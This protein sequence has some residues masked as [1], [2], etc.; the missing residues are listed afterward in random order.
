MDGSAAAFI[1]AIDQV[2]AEV[3]AAP[4]RYIKILKPVRVEAGR[5]FAEFRPHDGTRVEI[6]IDFANLL[7]G[8]QVFA[9]DIIGEV[10]RR[11]LARA[12]TFGFLADIEGLWAK[13]FALGASLDNAL[14][15]G[16]DRVINPEGMRFADECVRH[17]ALDA[18]GDLGLAGAP[19][20]GA[21]RSFRGGH[22][23]N[24]MALNALFADEDAWAWV[25][26]PVRRES[27]HADL[28]AGLSL[29][30][31]GPNVS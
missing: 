6:E 28:P 1:D 20:L 21:Y 13:G 14:V 7:I 31:F 29:P 15:F 30:A 22:K 12:R 9:G 18:I 4:R 27:G 3:L 25:E 5:S 10:F 11:E 17:K 24:V 19:I 8:R 16:D 23:L 26:M 2:G